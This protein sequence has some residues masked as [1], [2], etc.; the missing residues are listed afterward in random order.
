MVLFGRGKSTFEVTLQYLNQSGRQFDIIEPGKVFRTGF[1]G[2]NARFTQF[3]AVDNERVRVTIF[4]LVDQTVPESKRAEVAELITRINYT[5][6]IGSWDMGY[7]EGEL[8]FRTSIVAPDVSITVETVRVLHLINMME[9]DAHYSPI[10]GI[11]H[12]NM[13]ATDAFKSIPS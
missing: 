4:G 12:G 7:D 6:I 5:L 8:R 10:M 1:A 13:S 3:F 2:K 9:L 11:I